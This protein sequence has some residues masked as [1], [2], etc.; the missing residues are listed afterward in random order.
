MLNTKQLLD[1]VG[2]V[3]APD[4]VYLKHIGVGVFVGEPQY[5]ATGPRTHAAQ[6]AVLVE[7]RHWE[8]EGPLQG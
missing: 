3:R 6:G 1:G 4:H 5:L 2:Q 7:Y 8:L